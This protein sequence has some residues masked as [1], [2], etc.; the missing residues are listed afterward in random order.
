[1][2]RLR[3]VALIVAA[4][5]RESALVEGGRAL[6]TRGFGAAVI[7]IDART[8][9]G[10]SHLGL[11]RALARGETH[12]ARRGLGR[13]SHLGLCLP[14]ARVERQLAL[15]DRHA[16]RGAASGDSRRGLFRGARR[17]RQDRTTCN[18][19][20][21]FRK[22]SCQHQSRC[23]A[24]F[25]LSKAVPPTKQ[26]RSSPARRDPLLAGAS[27]RTPRRERSARHPSRSV[28]RFFHVAWLLATDGSLLLLGHC[29]G[30]HSRARRADRRPA[31]VTA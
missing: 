4:A 19:E 31:R 14:G 26:S 16:A 24:R 6:P 9:R 21:G 5:V 22:M 20:C 27:S 11:R 18:D 2:R 17:T 28:E 7:R 13:R 30:A 3:L 12:A 29:S 10:R 15:I 23:S 8:A 1:M 25:V